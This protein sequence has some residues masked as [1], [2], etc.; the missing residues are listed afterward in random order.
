MNVDLHLEYLSEEAVRVIP[1]SL[2]GTLWLQM[3]MDE[4]CWDALP[5]GGVS[6]NAC[7]APRMSQMAGLAS[8]TTFR[9]NMS[10]LYRAF[11]LC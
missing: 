5:V 11:S 7:D 3:N 9:N 4:D 10:A 1:E 8:L 6:I 2:H